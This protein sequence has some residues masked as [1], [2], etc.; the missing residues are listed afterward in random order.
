M[1]IETLLL[2]LLMLSKKY[3]ELPGSERM[4]PRAATIVHE[5]MPTENIEVSVYL[6][7]QD[8]DD[9]LAIPPQSSDTKSPRVKAPLSRQAV[10]NS[11]ANSLAKSIAKVVEFANESGLS[12][13][14]EDPARRLVK[15]AGPAAKIEAAF[16]TK[17]HYFHDGEKSFRARAGSLSAP[18]DV[19]AVVEAV[20]GLDTRPL[21]KPKLSFH[22]EPHSING[23]L[24][25][26]VAQLYD[27]P[28]TA[29]MGA[30][31]CIAIIELGG[32]FRANDNVVAFNAMGL[33]PPKVVPISVSG[34]INQ[35]GVDTNA[36]G[37]VALDIQVAGGAAP[38]AS[39]AVYFAPN[40]SQGFVDA[41]TRAAHDQNNKPNVISIS[42]GAAESGWTSQAVRAMNSACSDAA[43]LGVTVLAASGD[44]LATDRVNDGRA[45]VD[46]PASSPF[47]VG[48]G[49]TCID[50]TQHKITDETTWNTG[51]SGT[52]GG[53]SDIFDIPAYQSNA[54]VPRSVNGGRIGRGVPDVAGDGDPNSGY[55]IV[56]NGVG[57]TIGGTSAVAPLWAGLIALIN[58]ACG[59]P[60]GFVQPILYGNPKAFRDITKG[61]NK[62]GGGI[63]YPAVIGWDACTGLGAPLGNKLLSVF[64]GASQSAVNGAKSRGRKKHSAR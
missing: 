22:S 24:P 40:T 64:K 53:V 9:L 55:Q 30:G 10:A 6:K 32:G 57:G 11:R 27:F 50:V 31:Q 13:V 46:F 61:N 52:G 42:W 19:T 28:Q 34:G 29:G 45:H 15:I 4:S 38:G 51:G 7:D 16:R 35:P 36:D 44:D 59:H 26:E 2:E 41:I 58:E 25:N 48:C 56:V 17:L 8:G 33:S 37:E 20:L 43:R 60:V 39:I 14:K 18:E 47:V 5:V 62:N 1:L 21:A 54:N 49:G 63:G 12:V 3:V 23:H